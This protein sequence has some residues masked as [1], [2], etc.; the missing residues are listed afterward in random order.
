MIHN[1]LQVLIEQ[2]DE[3]LFNATCLGIHG[4]YAFGDSYAEALVNIHE[5]IHAAIETMKKKTGIDV[6]LRVP[7][8]VWSG[9]EL[10]A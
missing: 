1:R 8:V 5:K 4:C 10:S 7:E 6:D 9:R 2:D 3:G